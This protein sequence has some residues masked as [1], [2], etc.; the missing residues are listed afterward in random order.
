MLFA[1]VFLNVLLSPRTLTSIEDSDVYQ[2]LQKEQEEPQAPRQSGSFKALQDF[3]DSDGE[4]FLFPKRF[5]SQKHL[6]GWNDHRS[7]GIFV[8]LLTAN[9]E[10]MPHCRNRCFKGPINISKSAFYYELWGYV[11]T[12]CQTFCLSHIRGFW[13]SFFSSELVTLVWSLRGSTGEK[14]L[15][16]ILLCTSQHLAIKSV[17]QIWSKHTNTVLM[18]LISWLFHF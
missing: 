8:F 15:C 2:M 16:Y 11:W 13:I 14:R 4:F 9:K 18:K 6:T 5:P 17:I 7:R 3:I 10:K 1:C 12:L